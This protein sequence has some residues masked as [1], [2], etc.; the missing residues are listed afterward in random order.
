[1][2]EP[3]AS[4]IDIPSSKDSKGDISGFAL[5]V[6]AVTMPDRAIVEPIDRSMPRVRMTIIIPTERMLKIAVLASKS[7][8]FA[9][10]KKL[11]FRS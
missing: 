10:L 3:A 5:T 1:M 7:L 8:I 4:P 6:S 9:R 11:G 2:I